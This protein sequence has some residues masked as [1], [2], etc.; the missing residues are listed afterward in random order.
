MA[1]IISIIVDK[2]KR[3]DGIGSIAI[4]LFKEMFTEVEFL[5]M[6]YTKESKI[7]WLKMGGKFFEELKPNM[8]YIE[9]SKTISLN[10]LKFLK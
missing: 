8:L 9:C 4:D 2:E 1:E 7:F 6:V 5:I 10:H 3:K